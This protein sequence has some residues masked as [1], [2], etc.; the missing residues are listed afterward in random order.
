[1]TK[2]SVPKQMVVEGV[3]DVDFDAAR[4]GEGV[5]EGFEVATEA[6]LGASGDDVI[7]TDASFIAPKATEEP[8]Q[9]GQPD[10]EH[11]GVVDGG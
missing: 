7:G 10:R 11:F 6:R 9:Q 5:I 2:V 4:S 3:A 8:G 1:M